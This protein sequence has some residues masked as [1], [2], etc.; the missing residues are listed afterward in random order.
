MFP[1]SC[2]FLSRT[3]ALARRQTELAAEAVAQKIPG[4]EI[5][6]KWLTTLGD[7]QLEWSLEKTG[8]KGLFT[9]ELE[10]ALLAGEGD[11]AVH[12]AKDLPTEM[13]AGLVIAGYLPRA[14]PAD[15]L[16]K[17]AGIDVPAAIATGSPRRRAQ[18]SAIFP[19]AKFS[20]LR[21]NVET[22][23]KKIAA[24]EADATF[25]A[26]AG[27]A[28][29]GIFEFPGLVFE[30]WDSEKCIPAAGQGAIAL[31]TRAGDAGKISCF[32]DTATGIAVTVE[33]AFLAAFGEGCHSAFAVHC[34]EGKVYLFAGN[35][36]RRV[37]D[38]DAAGCDNSEAVADRVKTAL[39]NLG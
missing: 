38:F 12:S 10:N 19:E 34:R 16:V 2:T 26:A 15:V 14:D 24:G 22:R 21:G 28:R 9:S 20:E 17:R 6:T 5:T 30:R 32:C 35:L 7:R 25:L 36:G 31:Q 11:V 27:L 4:C 13:P 23:L 33:R 39:R 1:S 29:L 37:F 18:A 3:S 8:G